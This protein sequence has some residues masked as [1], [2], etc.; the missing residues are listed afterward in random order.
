MGEISITN[1]TFGSTFEVEIPDND[2]LLDEQKRFDEQPLLVQN[3]LKEIF[4]NE[5]TTK[6]QVKNTIPT[7]AE[8]MEA[9]DNGKYKTTRALNI[10][11]SVL[12]AAYDDIVGVMESK[13]NNT[14][15]YSSKYG[16]YEKEISG[17]VYNDVISKVAKDYDSSA[18]DLVTFTLNGEW[19]HV[20]SEL[21]TQ[22]ITVDTVEGIGGT[23]YR[24]IVDEFKKTGG[25]AAQKASELLNKHGIK[26]IAYNGARDG[27][28]FVIFDDAAIEIKRRYETAIRKHKEEMTKV[29]ERNDKELHQVLPNGKFERLENGD[30]IVTMPN[31]ARIQASTSGQIIV[32]AKEKAKAKAS[33]NLKGDDVIIRGSWTKITSAMCDGLLKLSDSAKR[34]TAFHEV[35][36]AVWDL[37]LSQKEKD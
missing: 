18:A 37:A 27:R 23:I 5:K 22:K 31:G 28:C 11:E 19:R 12:R 1:E 8:F 6:Y 16:F 7:F 20:L 29:V 34:G 24:R 25:N 36:H 2:V 26:G 3:A 13:K 4:P 32:N 10:K 33:H 21:L 17:F 15:T 30:Y 35:F 14:N 9:F